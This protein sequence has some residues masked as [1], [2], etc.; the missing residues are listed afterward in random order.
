MGITSYEERFGD[1]LGKLEAAFDALLAQDKPGSLKFGAGRIPFGSSSGILTDDS[2]LRFDATTDRLNV[3]NLVFSGAGTAFPTG[4]TNDV[5]FRTDRNLLYFYDGTNWLTLTI[6]EVQFPIITFSA[7]LEDTARLI[8]LPSDYVP[9]AI[10]F[11]IIVNTGATNT[12]A[13]YWIIDWRHGALTTIAT[14]NTAG[15]AAATSR[16][17]L[18]STTFTQPLL[19]SAFFNL[20]ATKNGTP[21]NIDIYAVCRYRYLG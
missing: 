14:V 12:G 10:Q 7:N 5:F 18:T 8:A 6:F 13:N 21:S 9:Y 20:R 17:R 19:V 16:L 15:L 4:F 3:N 1:R 11:D 2:N